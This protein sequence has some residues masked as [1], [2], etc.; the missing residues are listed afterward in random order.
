MLTEVSFIQQ[1]S[2]LASYSA[3]DEEGDDARR[4][5]RAIDR[6]GR[7]LERQASE[8][9]Q[10]QELSGIIEAITENQEIMR[11]TIAKEKVEGEGELIRDEIHI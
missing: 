10:R 2:Q 1:T 7:V 6:I 9:L 3:P 8:E 11:A 5:E 4:I